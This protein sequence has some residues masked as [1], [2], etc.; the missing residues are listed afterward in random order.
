[1][2][3]EPRIIAEGRNVDFQLV[4]GLKDGFSFGDLNLNTINCHLNITTM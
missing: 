2:G 4:G 1:M 3:L